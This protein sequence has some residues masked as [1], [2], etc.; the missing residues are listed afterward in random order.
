MNLRSNV[1]IDPVIPSVV[2]VSNGFNPSGEHESLATI[3]FAPVDIP[4][5]R[6]NIDGLLLAFNCIL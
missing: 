4:Y 5:Y 6:R 2:E 1:H 3:S